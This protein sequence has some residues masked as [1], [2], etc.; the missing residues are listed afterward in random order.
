MGAILEKLAIPMPD[1][2]T[3]VALEARIIITLRL[4]VTAHK[5]NQDCRQRLDKWLGSSMATT[6][7]LLID[8]TVG[9]AWPEA[10]RI[11]CPCSSQTTPDEILF[12]NMVRHVATGN[13]PAYDALLCEMIEDSA[14]QRIFHDIRNF[15]RVYLKR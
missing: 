7:F 9:F 8:E 13:R 12:L 4:A 10:F 2:R 3:L 15:S 14:R 6:R 11:G 5:T 1:I